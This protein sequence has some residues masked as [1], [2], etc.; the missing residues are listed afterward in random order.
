MRF[1]EYID[2]QA[3]YSMERYAVYSAD[4]TG[5]VGPVFTGPLS[6]LSYTIC[7]RVSYLTTFHSRSCCVSFKD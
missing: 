5:Q 7:I 6:A 1:K 4:A 2:T 3:N